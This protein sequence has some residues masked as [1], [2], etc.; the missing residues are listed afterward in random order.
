MTTEAQGKKAQA[1]YDEGWGKGEEGDEEPPLEKSQERGVRKEESGQ[2]KEGLPAATVNKEQAPKEGQES[3]VRSQES[4]QAK[5]AQAGDGSMLKAFKDTKRWA[6]TLAEE[7]AKLRE[8]LKAHEEGKVTDKE[9]DAARKAVAE[10]RDGFEAARTKAYEDYPELKGVL[11]PLIDTVNVL[12]KEN[13][14]LKKGREE[15]AQRKGRE[16]A[17][18]TFQRDIKPHVL[19]KHPDFDDVMKNEDYW[20][21]AEAQRPALKVAAMNSRDPE[22]IVW[23]VG[24]F[25]RF[26]A[27]GE[28]D[29][30]KE[31]DLKKRE[32]RMTNAMTV[33][34]GHTPFPTGPKKGSEDDYDAGWDLGKAARKTG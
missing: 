14:E 17:L 4:D 31:T 2:V 16:E 7:N 21:W 10:S 3:G 18:T 13:V 8:K 9:V 23:A 12:K 20:L 22:D 34:G 19:K 33:K 29:A 26:S 30:L 25:K 28:M 6:T 24:E 32:E 5:A 11:D 1:E 15:E 27:S